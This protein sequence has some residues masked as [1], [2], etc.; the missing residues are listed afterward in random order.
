MLRLAL[1]LGLALGLASCAGPRQEEVRFRN[2][3]V[4]LGGT[5]YLPGGSPPHPAVVLIHGDGPDTR[6]GYRLLARLFA[7]NGVAA[8][9]Y[10]KRG[11]GASSGDWRARFADLADDALAGVSLLES[12]GDIRPDRIGLWGGSQGGWIA[13]LA[14]SRSSDIAF[15][16]VKAGPATT[17]ARKAAATS[18]GRVRAAGYPEEVLARVRALMEIQFEILRSGRGWERLAAEANQVKGEPWYPHVAV[19]RHSRWDSSWMRYGPDIDYDPA[20]I[21]ERLTIPVLVLLG[22]LD[23]EVPVADTVEVLE[24]VKREHGRDITLRVFAGADHQLELPRRV[25]FRP[26]LAPGYLETTIEWT[27]QQVAGPRPAPRIDETERSQRADGR[28]TA[29]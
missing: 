12:R 20:P 25:S 26:R 19:M 18:L 13:P 29:P 15:L 3:E 7:R 16:I 11:T 4:E 2:G 21:Y 1:L 23:H 17:P 22:E 9:V 10:D 5:L 24:R 14:A 28:E 6:E 8:L 27:L